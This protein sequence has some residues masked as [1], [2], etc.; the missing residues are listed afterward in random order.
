M[1]NY[2]KSIIQKSKELE[3]ES[4]ELKDRLDTAFYHGFDINADDVER[5]TELHNKALMLSEAAGRVRG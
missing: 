3:K 1:T 2:Q 5:V 4:Q